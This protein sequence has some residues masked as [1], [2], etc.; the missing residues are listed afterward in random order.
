MI[1]VVGIELLALLSAK[2]S[3][4]H[5]IHENIKAKPCAF[6]NSSLN[7]YALY[8]QLFGYNRNHAMKTI[9]MNGFGSADL[10]TLQERPLPIPNEGEVRIQ[11]KASGFNPVDWKILEGWYGGDPHT[12]LGCECSGVVDAL[13]AGVK[14]FSV[15]DKV[16]AI[17]FGRTSNGS[18]AQFLCAPAKLVAK[19]PSNLSF[20]EASAIPL[21]AMTA[22]RATVACSA[23]KKGDKVFVA[24]AGGGVGSFAIQFLKM[25]GI[26]EIFTVAKDSASAQ[27]LQKNL[28]IPSSH[29]LIYEGLTPSQMKEQLIALNGGRLFDATL[30]L[31]GKEIKQLCIELTGYSGHFSTI[32]PEK[33]FNMPIWNEN[34]IPRIRNMS[35]HQIAV[36]AELGDDDRETWEIYKRHLNLISQML[37][38]NALKAPS[39][40]NLGTLSLATVQKAHVLLKSHRVKGKLVMT[41]E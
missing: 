20:E 32:L 5:F 2:T 30:D 24:G 23:F 16:Y 3:L 6:G 36:G 25:A 28:K 31:V 40:Q 39:V 8:T 17:T 34:A 14:E 22:Y 9:V 15:G 26:T 38:T 1:V 27:F 37:E 35:I 18:Y 41:M 33:D 19:M 13:G 21:A 7:I 10:L 11:I 12:I 29:I 4:F